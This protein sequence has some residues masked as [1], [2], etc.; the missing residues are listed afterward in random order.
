MLYVLLYAFFNTWCATYNSAH[1][2][3]PHLGSDTSFNGGLGQ[4]IQGVLVH[5]HGAT[6][7]RQFP[8]VPKTANVTIYCLLKELEKWRARHG[9][10]NPKVLY[11]QID[12]KYTFNYL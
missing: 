4:H 11:I 1:S 12:G 5:G 3:I 9:G 2:T 7:Y 6:L 8:S 10:R